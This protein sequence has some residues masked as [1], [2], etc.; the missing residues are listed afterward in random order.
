M[1]EPN[2]RPVLVLCRD[3]M[4]ASKIR[5]AA[6]DGIAIKLLRDPAQLIGESGGMLIVDL[7]QDGALEAGSS[8]KSAN[9][10]SRLIGFVAHVDHE[11]AE[12][13]QANG[14]DDVFTRRQ[15]VEVL[16]QLMRGE[17]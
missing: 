4:F 12:R 10:A 6:A 14:F 11:T 17:S 2:A 3:L 7:S 16:P 5:A 1:H 9:P 15:F 8:W 13:A